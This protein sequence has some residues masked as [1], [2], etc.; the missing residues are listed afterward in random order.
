MGRAVHPSVSPVQ[1]L[2]DVGD[3]RVGLL[4]RVG[5]VG[6]YA[7][8][9]GDGAVRA[10]LSGTYGRLL[11]R[12]GTMATEC[13]C[14][15]SH[16]GRDCRE[17]SLLQEQ[18]TYRYSRQCV[19]AHPA[20]T[21]NL[22]CWACL[23]NSL[24]LSDTIIMQSPKTASA[25]RIA[26]GACQ[27]ALILVTYGCRDTGD[28]L[29][30]EGPTSPVRGTSVPD[31]LDTDGRDGEHLFRMLAKA[32]PSSAGLYYDDGGVLVVRVRDARD[33]M[34]SLRFARELLRQNPGYNP[35]AGRLVRGFRVERAEYAFSELAAARNTATSS[36]LGFVEGVVMVDLDERANRVT[37][38]V[39]A[40]ADRVSL[41]RSEAVRILESKSIRP[42]I[43][44]FKSQPPTPREALIR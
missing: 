11:H 3:E 2:R 19:R 30:S 6:Q 33:D 44:A 4:S 37:I 43:L 28:A 36:L 21:K 18:T 31:D 42:G 1:Q 39:E 38:G 22:R 41:I 29:G 5:T 17:S 34:E 27:L 14:E 7:I 16:E 40:S 13:D 15:Q 8:G 24:E 23:E 25:C 20:L 9:G 26:F 10:G 12:N 35:G 32:A